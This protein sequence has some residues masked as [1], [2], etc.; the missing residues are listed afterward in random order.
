MDSI[1]LTGGRITWRAF[2]NKVMNHLSHTWLRFKLFRSTFCNIWL[3]EILISGACLAVLVVVNIF[4]CLLLL[5]L[6]D[7]VRACVCVEMH[8]G[9]NA[10]D[11]LQFLRNRNYW[12]LVSHCYGICQRFLI[13]IYL[14]VESSTL[15][16][17]P[18]TVLRKPICE[19]SFLC[20]CKIFLA[21]TC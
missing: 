3:T 1:K 21:F 9:T 20:K 8:C 19:C 17:K 4:G 6:R 10:V 14:L 13:G 11:H 12:L 18:P 5:L 7:T 15:F 2:L 16:G